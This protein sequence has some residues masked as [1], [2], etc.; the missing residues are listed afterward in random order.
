MKLS[1]LAEATIKYT[2]KAWRALDDAPIFEIRVLTGKEVEAIEERHSRVSSLPKD[3]GIVAALSALRDATIEAGIVA[4]L[5]LESADGAPITTGAAAIEAI[6]GLD[7]ATYEEVM[8]DLAKAI[9]SHSRL[10]EGERK[11]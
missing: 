3:A 2:P 4:V 10:K 1:K 6:R 5:N 11:N 8:E 9:K 7:A